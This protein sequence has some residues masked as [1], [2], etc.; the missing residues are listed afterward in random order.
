MI[1]MIYCKEEIIQIIQI[2]FILKN[3]RIFHFLL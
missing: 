1:I 3:I 2:H